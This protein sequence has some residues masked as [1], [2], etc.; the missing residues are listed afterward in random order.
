MNDFVIGMKCDAFVEFLRYDS[1]CRHTSDG[2]C[3]TRSAYHRRLNEVE[4]PLES[5]GY[6]GWPSD[7]AR[8]LRK[9]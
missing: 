3:K 7:A 5:V 4:N 9:I 8:M 2:T 1:R 6:E